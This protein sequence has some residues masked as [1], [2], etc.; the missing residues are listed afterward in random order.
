MGGRWTARIALFGLLAMAAGIGC[1]GRPIAEAP[2][3]IRTDAAIANPYPAAL[4]PQDYAAIFETCLDV[5]DDYFEIAY[6]NRYDG[7]I[8]THPKIAPGLEQP[9]KFGSPDLRERLLAMLQSIRYRGE[10]V[11][12]PA[13]EGGFN[14][15]VVVFKEVE[16]LARPIRATAGAASF[17]SDNTVDRQ[18]EVVDPS[19]VDSNWAPLGREC[20]LEQAIL[21]RIAFLLHC[22]PR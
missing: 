4:G 2:G 15:H 7:T 19:V 8:R 14:I 9:I 20:H 10:V 22:G 16:D 6:A 5:L 11:I 3:L 17:Q 21:Q 13:H 18:Y 1:A 12:E